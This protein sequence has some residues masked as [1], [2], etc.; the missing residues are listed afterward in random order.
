MASKKKDQGES[1]QDSV[2]VPSQPLTEDHKPRHLPDEIRKRDAPMVSD[3][4]KPPARPT[5]KP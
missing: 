1:R 5:K 2:R 4:Y 3:T